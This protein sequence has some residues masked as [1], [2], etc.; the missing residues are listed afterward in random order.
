VTQSH[1]LRRGRD[2]QVGNI[3][4]CLTASDNENIFINTEL[5]PLLELRGVYN[6]RNIANSID[7]GDVWCDMQ[8]RADGDGITSPL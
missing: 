8:T 3:H 2:S 5:L 7:D 6:G 4:A 1:R